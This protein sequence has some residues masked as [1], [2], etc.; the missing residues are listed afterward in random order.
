MPSR[1]FILVSCME[2]CRHDM[3]VQALP[4]GCGRFVVAMG[5]DQRGHALGDREPE[6]Q[7]LNGKFFPHDRIINRET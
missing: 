3:Q 4:G 2:H 1:F 5:M 7:N 6:Q